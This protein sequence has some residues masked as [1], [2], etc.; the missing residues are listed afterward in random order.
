MSALAESDKGTASV[1]NA[2]EAAAL[3]AQLT[4]VDG[5]EYC[6]WDRQIFK[7]LLAGG[8]SAVH[9][10]VAYHETARETLSR[11]G[12][13][14]RLFQAFNDLIC[15]VNSITDIRT[16]KTEGRVAIL[17]GAQNSS[18]IEDDIDLVALF[19]QL[20]LRVMQ[21]TYNNQ[22][23]LASGCF[24]LKDGGVTRFGREVI[25]E[26]NRV[27]MLIDLAHGGEV[28]TL[29]AAELSDRPIVVSHANPRFYHD[30]PRNVS[31]GEMTAVAETGGLL[32]LSAYP[33]HLP[34]GAQTPLRSFCDMAARAVDIMG[35]EHVGIGTDLCQNQP[36]SVLSWMRGGRWDPG[37]PGATSDLDW[38][39]ETDWFAQASDFPNLT[40][41]L[42]ARGFSKKEIAGIMGEN[43]L[44]VLSKT[45]DQQTSDE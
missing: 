45:T 39:A 42:A 12:E 37:V 30:T 33:R 27:G 18:P 38:P 35:V 26:M 11:I 2:N 6:N 22:S 40:A 23:L 43:W 32:G 16:A 9:A 34:N 3:H 20:G 8:V 13:W 29:D 24:E 4:I 36:V 41:G 14:N 1:L 31:E 15:P 19:R 5:V 28:S 10:T 7:Q 25:R 21:L 44:R 17:L